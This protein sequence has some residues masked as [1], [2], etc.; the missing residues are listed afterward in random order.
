MCQPCSDEKEL[1]FEVPTFE[2]WLVKEGH[3]D[4]I[5]PSTQLDCAF[6]AAELWTLYGLYKEAWPYD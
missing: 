5:W 1:T 2:D 4:Y 6:S 3:I